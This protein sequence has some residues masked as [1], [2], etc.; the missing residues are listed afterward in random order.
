MA[1]RTVTV[2]DV[3]ERDG[4]T[5]TASAHVS[6]DLGD[7]MRELDLCDKHL[8]ELR[9]TIARVLRTSRAARAETRRR[10]QRSKSGPTGARGQTTRTTRSTKSPVGT[11]AQTRSPK[12][13]RDDASFALNSEVRR[14][15]RAQGL[16]VKDRGR[17]P[18]TI[19]EQ[20]VSA[21]GASSDNG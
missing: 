8:T 11:S 15:A 21:T 3:D 2:C 19:V 20:Y 17:I 10:P 13:K 9:R 5:V 7:Q 6:L 14:W 18:N 12:S 4:K 1:Q 16:D